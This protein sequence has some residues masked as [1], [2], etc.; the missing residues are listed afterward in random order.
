MAI[1]RANCLEKTPVIHIAPGFGGI[2]FDTLAVDL[3]KVDGLVAYA[4]APIQHYLC[5]K[6][7]AV[8]GIHDA[9]AFQQRGDDHVEPFRKVLAQHIHG[10]GICRWHLVRMRCAKLKRQIKVAPAQIRHH[11]VPGAV[12]AHRL[13]QG[14][15][16][17]ALPHNQHVFRCVNLS[18]LARMQNA[19]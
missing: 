13:G 4:N 8:D 5:A 1:V 14:Q 10:G 18:K 2:D 15:P 12:Q 17:D 7:A 19:G 3:E 11:Q 6:G 16:A 9:V